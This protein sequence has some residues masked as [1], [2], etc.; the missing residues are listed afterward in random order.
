MEGDIIIIEEHHKRAAG[1]IVKMIIDDIYDTKEKYIITVGGESGSGKSE[2]AVSIANEFK[3]RGIKCY[4]FQQ[5]DYFIYPPK[6]NSKIR[7]NNINWVGTKEVKIGLLDSHLKSI[8]QGN[9]KIVKPLVI[10]KD[11]KITEETVNID[12]CKVVIA[13][14][15]YTTLLKNVDKHIFIDSDMRRTLAARR[16]RNRE[17]QDEFLEKVLTIEHNI[18]SSH[19]QNAE[20]TI[21]K[22]FN[23]ILDKKEINNE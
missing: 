6:T 15:T 9:N 13:E 23:A 22:D 20:I 21:T 16:K 12:E 7:K 2:I 5:D 19:R 11:N 1:Q 4:I 17:K 14:G 18:I 10:F 3:A 8:K